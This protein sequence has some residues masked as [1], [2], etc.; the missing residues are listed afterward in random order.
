MRRDLIEYVLWALLLAAILGFLFN[1]KF[2][3]HTPTPEQF[4]L[5]K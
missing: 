4:Q 5:T 3:R 1:K 2:S